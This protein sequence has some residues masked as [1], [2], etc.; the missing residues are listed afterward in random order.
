MPCARGISG[1]HALERIQMSR[2]TRRRDSVTT[3]KLRLEPVHT[4][5]HMLSRAR[6]QVQTRKCTTYVH[7]YIHTYKHTYIY[8]DLHTIVLIISLHTY[9]HNFRALGQLAVRFFARA[10]FNSILATRFGRPVRTH[11][12]TTSFRATGLYV[13]F[14]VSFTPT[15]F[16]C[17]TH[18]S[19]R[20]SRCRIDPKRTV[21]WSG[22]RKRRRVRG[23]KRT[24]SGRARGVEND[25]FSKVSEKRVTPRIGRPENFQIVCRPNTAQV[26]YGSKTEHIFG[27]V[28]FY[29]FA[30]RVG[31]QTKIY[32]W[33]SCTSQKL[34][35]TLDKP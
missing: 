3:V 29:D 22:R 17:Q 2:K 33:P 16:F 10:G 24:C 1:G 8:T 14:G 30:S 7:T 9:I 11:V 31:N 35:R 12:Q 6:T 4:R 13:T 26:A 28:L 18:C 5:K 23:P 21:L 27:N 19:F 20:C 34:F 32:C 15:F 25:V